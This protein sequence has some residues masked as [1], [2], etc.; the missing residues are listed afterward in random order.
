MG[1]LAAAVI[2]SNNAFAGTAKVKGSE[3]GSFVTSNFSYDGVSPALEAFYSGSDNL[4]GPFNG[5][6]IDEF[7]L[8]TGTC[9][10]PDGSAGEP[11]VLVEADEVDT[12]PQGQLIFG[13]KGS[14]AGTACAGDTGITGATL[15]LTV[16]C[17][18]IAAGQSAPS[19]VLG[20]FGACQVTRGGSVTLSGYQQND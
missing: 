13:G 8:T 9:T 5:Q 20:L 4:G 19:A 6:E 12:Y 11:F 10:G 3:A 16:I 7:A 17:P 18:T 1:G 14:A 2:A 15:T